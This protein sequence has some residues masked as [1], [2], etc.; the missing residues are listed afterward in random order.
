MKFSEQWLREWADPKVSSDELVEQLTCAGLEVDSVEPVVPEFTDVVVGKVLDVKQHPDADKLHVCH[1]DVGREELT[2]VCGAQNVRNGLKV[3]VAQVGAVLPDGLKIKK[4]KLRGVES[5]GMICSETELKLADTSIGIMELPEDAPVG[6]SL[7]EYLQLNDHIIDIELTPNRGD[8][9][10]ILGVAREVAA[11]Y[12]ISLRKVDIKPV[13]VTI[14]DTIPVSVLNP[15]QCPRYI[16][17]IIKN[18]KRNASIPMGMKEKLR[19][20]GLRSIHPVVDITNYVMLELGQPMHAFDVDKLSGGIE[21]RLAKK[22]EGVS[23]LGEQYLELDPSTLV[24]AD[25]NGIQAIAGVK[26]SHVTGVTEE[27][28]NIFLESAFFAP[29][30][31]SGAARRYGLFTDSS[32]RFERGVDPNLQNIAIQRASELILSLLGGE[33]GPLIEVSDV[34]WLPKSNPIFLRYDRIQRILGISLPKQKIENILQRLDMSFHQTD[35]GW[36]ITPPSYRSDIKIEIDLIEELAR[37]Y[38][39]SSIPSRK[40]VSEMNILSTSEITLD[41]RRVRSLMMDRGYQEAI[42]YSFVDPHLE[43]LL[44]PNQPLLSLINPISSELSVMRTNQWSGL[45]Q[46]VLHNQNRQQDRVRLFELGLCF[47]ENNTE[48]EQKLHMGGIITGDVYQ[49]QWGE[50]SRKVDFFDIKSDVENILKL[51]GYTDEFKFVRGGHPA[52][53]PGKSAAIYKGSKLIGYLGALHPDLKQKLDVNNHVYLFDLELES[54]LNISLPNY[55]IISKFPAIRRDIAII[56][57]DS[58]PVEQI[59]E[60]ILDSAGELLKNVLIF[61]VYQGK[62]IEAGMKSIALGLTFQHP[63]RTLVDSEINEFMQHLIN[64]LHNEFNATLR[65]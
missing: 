22:G 64:M 51:T 13:P 38:G 24:I 19:R 8:C 16:G 59:L 45:I 25:Q 61:D 5:S 42:T 18:I 33:A 2:I 52:L 4:V 29:E 50:S 65:D 58:I 31:I 60:K 44:A 53:H 47:R 3:P 56:V 27:T 46:A 49:E 9:L 55:Q 48:I 23:L 21:V 43:Q 11:N 36:E 28:Q 35:Q 15:Q 30:N 40:L 6:T 12:D 32:H 63:S 62:G 37:I 39:Y 1:V 20:S 7:R 10:S 41:L 54:M 14:K 26:G 17:R 57:S 34:N